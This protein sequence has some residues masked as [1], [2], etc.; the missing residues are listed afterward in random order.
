MRKFGGSLPRGR[1]FLAAAASAALFGSLAACG[2]D[3]PAK[4]KPADLPRVTEQQAG[5]WSLSSLTRSCATNVML[6]TDVWT[7]TLHAGEAWFGFEDADCGAT[8]T[9]DEYHIVCEREAT[10]GD[11]CISVTVRLDATFTLSQSAFTLDA[12]QSATEVPDGCNGSG[13]PC[14]RIA[15]HGT[16]TAGLP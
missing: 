8:V 14:I 9:G 12:R 2:D 3:D 4:P 7:D 16:R 11:S 1:A 6:E 15:V 13:I 5:I 10:A